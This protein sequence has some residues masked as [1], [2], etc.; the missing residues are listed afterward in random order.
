LHIDGSSI[1]GAVAFINNNFT[2]EGEANACLYLNLN[3]TTGYGEYLSCFQTGFVKM[4]VDSNGGIGNYQSFD[5]D[6]SDIRVKN[7]ITSI[8]SYWNKIKDI[9]II[10]Y[11]YNNQTDDDFNI[12][13]IAQQ[14]ESIAPEFVCNDGWKNPEGEK[15]KTVYNKDLYFASIK[16]LQ[17]A[18]NKIE[19]L[20]NQ[21]EELKSL[22]N[23]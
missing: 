2:G 19:N 11:K 17:E 9:E 6:L 18:M 22:I 21:I 5:Q 10:K 1:D 4:F 20:E 7:S 8:D 15:Y 13:V 12:G 16:V 3:H 14:V 23:K